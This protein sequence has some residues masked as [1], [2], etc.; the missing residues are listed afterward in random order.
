MILQRVEKPDFLSNAYLVVDEPGGHGVL[1]DSNGVT[2]PLVERVEREGTEI[3][4]VLLTHHHWDHVLTWR[5][6]RKRSAFRC[7]RIRRPR[8]YWRG[9]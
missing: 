1:I 2:E 8:S 6:S 4:H 5:S 3:T 7:W 9:R